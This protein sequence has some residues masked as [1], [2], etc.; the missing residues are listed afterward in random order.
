[1]E[2]STEINDRFVRAA[3]DRLSA[4]GRDLTPAMK[5]I[6]RAL[7]TRVQLCFKISRDPYG[8]K[9][10]GLKSRDGKPLVDKG[11]LRGSVTYRAGR[12]SVT[13]GTNV[14]YARTHQFGAEIEPL[15]GQRHKWIKPKKAKALKI[16]LKSGQVIF[17]KGA[18]RPPMLAFKIGARWVYAM[19]VTIP[20]R[21]FMPQGAL[22]VSWREEILEN[23]RERFREA[24]DG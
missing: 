14:K 16:T 20:A 19:K 4:A 18:R 8:A 17:R 7:K 10:A 22:P 9:W 15:P 21:P 1:M 3:L 13:V 24:F 23:M 5:G 11:R 12:D 2:I 6:G